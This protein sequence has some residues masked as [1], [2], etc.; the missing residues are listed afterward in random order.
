MLVLNIQAVA[1]STLIATE[2]LG[3]PTNHSVT[4]N[5][6]AG[7]D[8]EAFVKYGTVSG[9]YADH[10]DT[11]TVLTGNP[12]ELVIDGLQSN[13]LYYYRFCYRQAGTAEFTIR[14]EHYFRTQRA[15]GTTYRFTVES[16]PHLYDK[17]GISCSTSE[18][19]SEMTITRIQS[20]ASRY[21]SSI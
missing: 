1:Q 13:R 18:I 17:K 3:R 2:I 15:R 16:D 5:A 8:A 12:I 21:G 10:T 20:Q 9:V 6:V 4:V 19:H 11:V 7:F 14:D